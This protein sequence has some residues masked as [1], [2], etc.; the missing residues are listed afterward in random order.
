MVST[1]ARAVLFACLPFVSA[2]WA[3]QA[4]VVAIGVAETAAFSVYQIIIAQT[5]SEDL[6]TQALAVRRTLGNVGF[7]IAAG[8]TAV[9][10]ASWR[11][12]STS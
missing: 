12:A 7:T 9:V 3:I 6:R 2:S 1:T 11:P 5:L 10:V 8:L 4:L